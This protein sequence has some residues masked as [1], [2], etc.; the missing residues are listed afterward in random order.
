MPVGST[1]KN[2]LEKQHEKNQDIIVSVSFVNL[3]F[4]TTYNKINFKSTERNLSVVLQQNQR[5]CAS[6]TIKKVKGQ[7]IDLE[8]ICLSYIW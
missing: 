3:R 8:K 2:P 4:C 5:V 1:F 6:K 7:S